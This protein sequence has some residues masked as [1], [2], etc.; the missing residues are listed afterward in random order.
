MEP[1][2]YVAHRWLMHG[3]GMTWHASHHR[4][5]A[6][7][8][9]RRDAPWPPLDGDGNP[10]VGL[11]RNDRFPVVFAA[12]TISAMSLGALVPRLRVLLPVG[13][14][15]TAYGLTYAVVHDGYIHQR[16]PWLRARRPLLEPLAEAHALHHRY[17]AEPYG[18]LA[19]VV[20][21]S[22]RLRATA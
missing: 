5:N 7:L 3:P 21:R 15:V 20:P 6:R 14:G 4:G 1:V 8:E 16:V 2:T 12:T 9:R 19:P 18:M 13:A 22:V 11:E 17:G 10:L